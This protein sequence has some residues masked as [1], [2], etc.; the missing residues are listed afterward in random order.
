MTYKEAL[1]NLKKGQTVTIEG[2]TIKNAINGDFKIA[3]IGELL[4]DT[5]N[6]YI[7]RY[8]GI[9]NDASFRKRSF[10][11]S[12]FTGRSYSGDIGYISRIQLEAGKWVYR[13]KEGDKMNSHK[14]IGKL[15]DWEKDRWNFRYKDVLPPSYQSLEVKI[16]LEDVDYNFKYK[17]LDIK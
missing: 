12:L 13:E 5:G 8:A 6:F 17:E 14:A 16:K 1:N 11:Y 15:Y 4:D 2:S 10:T 9:D 7:M 3:L